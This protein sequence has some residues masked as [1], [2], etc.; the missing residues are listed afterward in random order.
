MNATDE[1][2]VLSEKLVL[3]VVA[4]SAAHGLLGL[5]V[6]TEGLGTMVLAVLKSMLAGSNCAT[7][8]AEDMVKLALDCTDGDD[9][10]SM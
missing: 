4:E 5:T 8:E 1:P 10:Y 7:M 6:R 9:M 2:T 3:K